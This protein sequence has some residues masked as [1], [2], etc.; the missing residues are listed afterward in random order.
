[1]YPSP[2]VPFIVPLSLSQAGQ[3]MCVRGSLLISVAADAA[4]ILRGVWSAI[5]C[6]KDYQQ[7]K[8]IS[9]SRQTDAA[10]D[11]A[12]HP[13]RS[14]RQ[15]K[16]TFHETDYGFLSEACPAE[17]EQWRRSSCFPVGFTVQYWCSVNFPFSITLRRTGHRASASLL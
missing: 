15:A 5:G 4:S 13:L 3:R 10:E 17:L 14:P 8:A 16:N 11:A 2:E 6:Y 7:G 9:C 12:H 1:M